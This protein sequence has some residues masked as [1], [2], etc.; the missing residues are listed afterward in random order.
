MEPTKHTDATAMR[1]FL[2]IPV[3]HVIIWV[4]TV[5]LGARVW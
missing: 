3:S 4:V 2:W 1:L 5:Y